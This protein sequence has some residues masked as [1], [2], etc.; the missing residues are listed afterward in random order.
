[1]IHVTCKCRSSY[2]RKNIYRYCAVTV[3]LEYVLM[4]MTSVSVNHTWS[5]EG[6]VVVELPQRRSCWSWSLFLDLGADSAARCSS[7]CG[8]G[9][10]VGGVKVQLKGS[11]LRSRQE[12]VG[13]RVEKRNLMTPQSIL[14]T[15]WWSRRCSAAPMIWTCLTIECALKEDKNQVNEDK[16]WDIIDN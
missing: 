7:R 16:N 11:Q 15:F 4:P 8:I 2:Y 3:Y 10:V 13:Q 9:G 14:A 6:S 12:E 5:I 1:M